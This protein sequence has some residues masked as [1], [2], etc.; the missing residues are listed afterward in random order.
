MRRIM[1]LAALA[2]SAA[3]AAAQTE[4]RPLPVTVEQARTLPPARVADI[5]LRDLATQMATMTRPEPPRP[6]EAG[7]P[8]TELTFAS[9]PRA[10]GDPGLCVATLVHVGVDRPSGPDT[11]SSPG[12]VATELVYKVVGDLQPA[13]WSDSDQAAQ[14]KLCAGTGPVV[15]PEAD[16]KGRA[17]FFASSGAPLPTAGVTA[18][19]QAI[20]K[21]RAGT[22]GE[23]A[24]EDP[25][26]GDEAPSKCSDPVAILA[27]LD[28]ADLTWLQT[29]LSPGDGKRLQ[30]EAQLAVSA[31][32]F[33]IVKLECEF[34]VAPDGTRIFRPVRTEIAAGRI[35][36][37]SEDL[38]G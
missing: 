27:G 4:V 17:Y 15:S 16:D 2:A 34:S 30:V 18:L 35:F 3:P 9:A 8:P 33:W 11:L 36:N 38:G 21:A 19:Q 24:C 6:G 37:L 31:D 23:I 7:S 22:Y 26:D 14:E 32:A 20:G 10:A 28:L 5:V 25:D 13:S 1:S 12:L 29:L